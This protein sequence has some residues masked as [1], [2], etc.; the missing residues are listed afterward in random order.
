M[1]MICGYCQGQCQHAE[2]QNKPGYNL[3]ICQACERLFSTQAAGPV[4]YVGFTR[5]NL[6]ENPSPA[7]LSQIEN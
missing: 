1:K 2:A 3:P 4:K 5:E 6:P 7:M